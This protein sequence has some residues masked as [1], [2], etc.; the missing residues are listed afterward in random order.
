[1]SAHRYKR[2]G[3]VSLKRVQSQALGAAVPAPPPVLAS[4]KYATPRP[5]ASGAAPAFLPSCPGRPRR[6]NT[7]AP[8][9]TPRALFEPIGGRGRPTR[10]GIGTRSPD[11]ARP[12]A[13][14][15]GGLPRQGSRGRA[16]GRG[17]VGGGDWQVRTSRPFRFC[18]LLFLRLNRPAEP[19]LSAS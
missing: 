12:L 8:G 4:R 19:T 3:A 18:G 16:Q 6:G 7:E 14:G 2:A 11:R 1:M 10:P 9:H 15:A 5:S 17:R 13:L